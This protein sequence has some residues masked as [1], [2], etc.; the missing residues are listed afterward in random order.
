MKWAAVARLA[1]LVTCVGLATSRL[2]LLAH[3]LVG[4]GGAATL[5]GGHVTAVR[6]FWFAG[7]W[8][9]YENLNHGRLFVSMGGIGVELVVGAAIALLL[10]RKRSSFG[11][12]IVRCVGAALVIHAAWYLATGTFHGYGDGLYVHDALGDAS[13]VVWL[14]AAILAVTVAFVASRMALGA[15][16]QVVGGSAVG[17]AVALLIGLGAQLGASVAEVRLR[18]DQSYTRMMT[19]ENTRLAQN[20]YAAWLAE[21]Q[22][23]GAV[24]DDA[25]RAQKQQALEDSHRDFPFAYLLGALLGVAV[26]VGALR[27]RPAPDAMLS[28]RL[29]GTAAAIAV[30]SIAVVIA[31]GAVL[32]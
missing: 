22:K 1:A 3:E 17:V 25:Q 14:P 7:G 2:G 30:G 15:F 19:H 32:S 23:H 9:R 8:V 12:V 29:L 28:S 24:P 13:A 18:R 16:V 10:M 5:M 21:Q 20:E 4:H 31:I 6:L 11:V 27:R 26:L